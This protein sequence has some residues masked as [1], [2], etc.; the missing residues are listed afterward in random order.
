MSD[1]IPILS[2]IRRDM[3]ALQRTVAQMSKTHAQ[4]LSEE[5]VTKE[6]VMAIL[7][8]SPR[9][10]ETFKR[11]GILPFTKIQGMFYFRTADIEN[12]LKQNYVKNGT[13]RG[14]GGL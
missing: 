9:T 12:L 4:Q 13:A 14:S 10:L 7:K 2:G 1:I 5:W 11:K 8:I 3:E 6:Q